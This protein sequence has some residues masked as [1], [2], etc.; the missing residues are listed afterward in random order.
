MH[1]FSFL[2]FLYIL[3]HLNF[4]L[5][6]FLAI[7]RHLTYYVLINTCDIFGSSVIHVYGSFCL[8]SKFGIKRLLIQSKF[9]FIHV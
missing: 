5:E 2:I 6:Y 1:D 8:Y 4:E 7:E 3:T 9:V